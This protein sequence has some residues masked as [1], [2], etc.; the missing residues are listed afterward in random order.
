MGD[1]L[2]GRPHGHGQFFGIKGEGYYV[3]YEGEYAYGVRSGF[4]VRNYFNGEKY[5]GEWS[6]NVR[7]GRGKMEYSNGDVYDG[8]WKSDR[9]NGVGSHYYKNGDVFL[10]TYLKDKREGMGTFYMISKNKKYVAEYCDDVPKCGSVL[11]I[12]DGDLCPLEGF[13]SKMVES[14]RLKQTDLGD[15]PKQLPPLDLKQPYAV[16]AKEIEEARKIRAR[17]AAATKSIQDFGGT[18]GHVELELLRH[19]FT[20]LVGGDSI[21]VKMIP[22]QLQDLCRLVG[23]D[24]ADGRTQLLIRELLVERNRDGLIEFEGFLRVVSHFRGMELGTIDFE[25]FDQGDSA[26][27]EYVDGWMEGPGDQL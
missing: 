14:Q 18:M 22:H 19:S 21:D 13:L 25:N 17:D 15:A 23:L 10:G 7:C 8:Q 20:K 27:E 26:E 24:P 4:G 6:S 1:V 11:E 3:E 16:V 12:E 9:R 2:A 5:S